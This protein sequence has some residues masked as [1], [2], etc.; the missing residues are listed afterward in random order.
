MNADEYRE[1]LTFLAK[2]PQRVAAM[3]GGVQGKAAQMRPAAD[4]FSAVE[5]ACH[6]RDIETEG[7]LLRA[8]RM[9]AEDNPQ[10]AD[11]DGGKLAAERD[12]LL[13]DL[14]AAISI[15]AASR[16]ATLSILQNATPA[17]C[18]RRGRFGAAK[19]ITLAELAGMMRTHDAEHLAELEALCA[20]LD[21]AAAA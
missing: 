17:E 8:R 9:V 12:Y 18:L 11:I 6:L 1:T 5:Q 16:E 3:I 20:R 21:A 14:A 4:A 15:F 2:T 13:Q 10:L 19:E 7:Y